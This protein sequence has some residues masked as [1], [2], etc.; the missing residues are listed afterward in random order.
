MLQQKKKH[1]C[2]LKAESWKLKT[3][4]SLVETLVYIAILA[5]TLVS[6]LTAMNL[7]LR[8]YRDASSRSELAQAGRTAMA[9]LTHEMRNATG[10]DATGS[11]FGTTTGMLKLTGTDAFGNATTTTFSRERGSLMIK[12]GTAATSSLLKPTVGAEAF[13][14]YQITT[15]NS[16]AV[17]IVLTLEAATTTDPV[18]A[19]F[20]GTTVLRGSY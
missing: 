16:R 8:T 15:A 3:G 5:L 6:L 13:T 1:M 18:R 11:V 14:V 19:T 4:Y 17:R 2:L 9:R 7:M 10:I 12:M 20:Y